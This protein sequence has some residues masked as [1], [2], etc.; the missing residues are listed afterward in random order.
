M[1]ST[2][3]AKMFQAGINKLDQFGLMNTIDNL[4]GGDVLKYDKVRKLKYNVVFDKQ[5]R[6]I[7]LSEISKN[8]LK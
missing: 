2:P 3:N 1:V 5:Y 8:Y 4:A 6:E 7:I